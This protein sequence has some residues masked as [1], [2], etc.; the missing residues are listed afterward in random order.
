MATPQKQGAGIAHEHLGGIVIIVQK[1]Q[2]AAEHGPGKDTQLREAAPHGTHHRKE[3]R[4][5]QRHAGGQAVQSVGDV[6]GVHRTHDD[7]GSEDHVHHPVHDD[8][9]VEEGDIQVG[10][11]H[12]LVAHKAQEGHRRRQ[13]ENEL[14]RGRQAGILMVLHLLI[15]VDVADDAEHQCKGV[16]IQVGEAALQHLRP[17]RRQNWPRRCR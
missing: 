14:L 13:L 9:G 8:V 7:E 12:P 6:D 15:V 4:H 10:A 11:Q 17:A 16:D 5:R 3:Q 1:A 2:Q